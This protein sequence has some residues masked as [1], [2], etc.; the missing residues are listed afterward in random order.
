M[1]GLGAAPQSEKTILV[2][3]LL[4]QFSFDWL[5]LANKDVCAHSYSC[6]PEM[7]LLLPLQ[8]CS[9]FILISSTATVY[10]WQ[11]IKQKQTTIPILQQH[12]NSCDC[13]LFWQ[14]WFHFENIL[15]MFLNHFCVL[16][17][18]YIYCDVL[19]LVPSLA[20]N[21]GFVYRKKKKKADLKKKMA[22]EKP[23][24]KRV[25]T[26]TNKHRGSSQ[27]QRSTVEQFCLL[28]FEH[29]FISRRFSSLSVVQW[30]CCH[31]INET[32]W[33]A[34]PES[35]HT[36]TQTHPPHVVALIVWLCCIVVLLLSV[37][38]KL[39]LTDAENSIL[40][41]WRYLG[42]RLQCDGAEC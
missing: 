2:P 13:A 27:H 7:I 34:V 8:L 14:V 26:K 15:D 4:S 40:P 24:V 29:S 21:T 23:G 12:I 42:S 22:G 32:S 20:L 28:V 11:K 41:L 37:L 5:L 39:Q 38:I 31:E 36:Y 17:K 25:L 18:I 9:C 30:A 10:I 16:L 35:K 3:P 19:W 1:L 33:A 6:V